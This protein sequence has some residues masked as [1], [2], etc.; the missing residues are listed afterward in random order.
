[1][2]LRPAKLLVEPAAKVTRADQLLAL[3]QPPANLDDVFD[4]LFAEGA[5]RRDMLG[6]GGLAAARPLRY[7]S[8]SH[9]GSSLMLGTAKCRLRFVRTSESTSASAGVLFVLGGLWWISALAL[10]LLASSAGGLA[11]LGEPRLHRLWLG[12]A[13]GDELLD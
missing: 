4:R 9:R 2:P 7:I 6:E 8:H 5:D 13:L 10:A 1:M 12:I 3:D 11:R